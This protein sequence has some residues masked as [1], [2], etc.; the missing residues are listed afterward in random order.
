[1]LM[2]CCPSKRALS[3][4]VVDESAF[5]PNFS[6]NNNNE[7]S[8]TALCKSEDN[9]KIS[10]NGIEPSIGIIS[11]PKTEERGI[12]VGQL[13]SVYDEIVIRCAAEDWKGFDGS[14]LSPEKNGDAVGITDGYC[15]ADLSGADS[16]EA[17]SLYYKNSRESSFP[18]H[19]LKKACE[20][21][22]R[23]AVASNDKDELHI[24]NAIVNRSIYMIPV[25]DHHPQYDI[26]NNTLRGKIIVPCLDRLLRHDNLNDYLKILKNS[27]E[28]SLTLM[29]LDKSQFIFNDEMALLLSNNM[30]ISLQTIK[31]SIQDCP[32]GPE[33]TSAI[34]SLP[35][36]LP[37]L[38]KLNLIG[39]N[40]GKEAAIAL[41]DSLH[42]CPNISSLELNENHFDS[43]S[44][45]YLSKML[46]NNHNITSLHLQNNDLGDD[47]ARQIAHGLMNNK[48]I[49]MLDLS[50][51]NIGSDG[52]HEISIAILNDKTIITLDL[53]NNL[54][55]DDG[56]Y[57]ISDAISDNNSIQLL[58]LKGNKIG[59]NGAIHISNGLKNNRMIASLDI[60]DNK[61]GF[62]GAHH[63]ANAVIIN[64]IITSLDLSNNNIG[65][66]GVT[67]IS[68]AIMNNNNNN[69]NNREI[70]LQLYNNDNI[71][72]NGNNNASQYFFN[73]INGN[74]SISSLFL[75]NANNNISDDMSLSY[76]NHLIGGNNEGLDY[77]KSNLTF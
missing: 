64:H 63:I 15:D 65:S 22:I 2:G 27:V 47:G 3:V 46:G 37:N 24:K 1:M 20:F 42:N 26:L 10:C 4:Q 17:T 18:T 71:E 35:S 75:N 76:V 53:S 25:L 33:G 16:N 62:E 48:T 8:L 51:N 72:S 14:P 30:P 69:N 74:N 38:T 52:A 57:H 68:D 61:I 43:E 19:I 58:I 5:N 11:I 34:F 66:E 6:T 59:D 40:Y 41:C 70:Q 50:D 13:R 9:S 28:T 67:N 56:A 60:S 77:D 7:I 21:D 44:S 54:I 45:I 39:S 55:G 36:K 31:I 49:T 29:Y 23:K 73:T 32:V 12:T